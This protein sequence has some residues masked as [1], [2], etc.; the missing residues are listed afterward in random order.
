MEFDIEDLNNEVMQSLAVLLNEAS[1]DFK[2]HSVKA[3]ALLANGHKT[4]Q[5]TL[6]CQDETVKMRV[7]L[8]QN[9]TSAMSESKMNLKT[10][11]KQNQEK[12]NLR[13][14]L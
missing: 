6:K 10:L 4:N 8:N 5:N 2:A 11:D 3:Q 7:D 14:K 9:I 12:Q 1:V 13:D